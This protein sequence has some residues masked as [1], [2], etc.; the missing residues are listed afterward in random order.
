MAGQA[1][2]QIGQLHSWKGTIYKKIYSGIK[3]SQSHKT[4]PTKALNSAKRLFKQLS[5]FTCKAECYKMS[6]Q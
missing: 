6:R 4:R 3:M 2:L 5:D 1:G